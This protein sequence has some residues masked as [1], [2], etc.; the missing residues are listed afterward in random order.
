MHGARAIVAGA[1][2]AA[3]IAGGSDWIR[4]AAAQTPSARNLAVQPATAPLLPVANGHVRAL[5]IG[6][7]DYTA[8]TRL[9]GAVAD[10][11]D[12]ERALRA[13]GVSDVTLLLDQQATRQNVLAAV[14]SLAARVR[15]GD[16]VLVAFSGHGAKRREAVPGSEPDGLDEFF[17]LGSYQ[18]SGERSGE[19]ILDNEMRAL[20]ADLSGKGA[21]TVFLA[22]SCFGGGMTKDPNPAGA[23]FKTRALFDVSLVGLARTTA[24]RLTGGER[25]LGQLATSDNATR[26][27]PRLSF[28]AAVE[29]S[30]PVTEVPI[31]GRPR[32]AASHA[33]AR[34]LEGA[35][36]RAGNQDGITTRGELFA[37]L[38]AS[39]RSTTGHRQSPVV[40]P[41]SPQ[42]AMVPLFRHG[43]ER[44]P[45]VAALGAT[46]G[47]ASPESRLPAGTP[48]RH[49]SG[50]VE[51]DPASGDVRAADGSI[52]IYGSTEAAFAGAVERA[53]ALPELLRLA[54]VRSLSVGLN[55]LDGRVR[56]QEPIELSVA[57]GLYGRY[58]LLAT[59]AGDGTVT[60]IFPT[61]RADPYR[62]EDALRQNLIA[63]RTPGFDTLI[64]VA[65][66]NRRTALE[67]AIA[68][69]NGRRDSAGLVQALTT[70]LGPGDR[71]GLVSYATLPR[72]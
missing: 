27:I 36:D 72:R 17:V 15:P 21:E 4:T 16:L 65:A 47:T 13:G 59:L 23:L 51:R 45:V 56:V 30:V 20:L 70:H 31:D 44:P 10:A 25:S 71:L 35:A 9:D 14:S 24:D 37:F 22:D 69:L 67:R 68:D 43:L 28:I 12:L 5:L 6:I 60:L 34:A 40:E 38:R 32:G 55:P 7:D 42:S 41:R 62:T 58:L 48:L 49:G 18:P 3:G 54:D 29:D 26:E 8:A 50:A 63:G 39:I 19:I 33:L 46:A 11:R 61:G 53:N 2:V 66:T 52:L 64:L 57:A 1:L